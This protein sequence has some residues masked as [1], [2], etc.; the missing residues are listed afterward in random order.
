M[1]IRHD[2]VRFGPTR[3]A[4]HPAIINDAQKAPRIGGNAIPLANIR[5]LTGTESVPRRKPVDCGEVFR[6]W[7]FR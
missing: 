6:F 3:P 1:D 5:K 7:A 4:A 2:E